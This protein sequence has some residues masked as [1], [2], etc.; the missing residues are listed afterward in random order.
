MRLLP[1]PAKDRFMARAPTS[2][3]WIMARAMSNDDASPEC[4]GEILMGT[5]RQPAVVAPSPPHRPATPPPVKCGP[6]L[7]RAA[8]TPATGVP[9]PNESVIAGTGSPVRLIASTMR[10]PPPA[11]GPPSSGCAGSMPVSATASLSASSPTH[12]AQ[13]SAACTSARARP[14]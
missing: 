14:P 5:I 7:L 2:A 1:G 10:G 3:A 6:S 12:S 8:I 11:S 4:P 9:W 13:P